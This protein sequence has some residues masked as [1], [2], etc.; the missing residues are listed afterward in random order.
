M[1]ALKQELDQLFSAG[2]SSEE[3]GVRYREITAKQDQ[4]RK[5]AEADLSPR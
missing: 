5:E 2:L 1:D 4:L 3:I